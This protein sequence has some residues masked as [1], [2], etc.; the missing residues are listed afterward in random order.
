MRVAAQL[1]DRDLRAGIGKGGGLGPEMQG[2]LVQSVL[3]VLRPYGVS[4]V[5][6]Y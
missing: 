3:T 4:H 2:G 1:Q 5:L 6:H